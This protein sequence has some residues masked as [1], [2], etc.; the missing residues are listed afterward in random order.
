MVK[1]PSSQSVLSVEVSGGW[2]VIFYR[3][4]PGGSVSFDILKCLVVW[5]WFVV[6]RCLGVW[7]GFVIKSV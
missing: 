1:S 4:V 6:L 2:D 5:M 3:E 7:V